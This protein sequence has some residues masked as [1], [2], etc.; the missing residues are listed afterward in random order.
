M[1]LTLGAWRHLY[2]KF[3]LRYDPLYWGAVFPLGMYTACTYRLSE[4]LD[5]TFLK[6]LP[7]FFIYVAVAGWAIVFLGLVHA[8]F[9]IALPSNPARG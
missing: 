6:P 4:S 5:V 1:L 3:P 9:R 2:M 8:F 7:D